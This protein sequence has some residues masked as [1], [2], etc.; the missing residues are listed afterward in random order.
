MCALILSSMLYKVG[1][2]L[3]P[4]LMISFSSYFIS[5]DRFLSKLISVPNNVGFE[6]CLSS[7]RRTYVT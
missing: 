3:L 6:I 7:K 2:Q 5:A 1:E 4:N